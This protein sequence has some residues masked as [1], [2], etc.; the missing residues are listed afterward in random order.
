MATAASRRIGALSRLISL[1]DFVQP[2]AIQQPFI[3][4]SA[5]PLGTQSQW[6]G[7]A[8]PQLSQSDQRRGVVT[9]RVENGKVARAMRNLV[10]TLWADKLPEVMR[11]RQVPLLAFLDELGIVPLYVSP[12]RNRTSNAWQSRILIV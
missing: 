3:R 5:A 1:R 9:I 11:A 4:G 10:R 12:V 6:Q 2:A 7:L 8:Q